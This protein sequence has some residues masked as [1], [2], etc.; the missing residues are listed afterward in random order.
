MLQVKI[1]SADFVLPY[2][3]TPKVTQECMHA[4]QKVLAFD[5]LLPQYDSLI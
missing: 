3:R 5:V 1:V 2:A 4:Y